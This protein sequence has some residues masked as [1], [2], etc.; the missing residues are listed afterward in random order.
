MAA[1]LLAAFSPSGARAWRSNIRAAG[2]LPAPPSLSDSVAPFRHHLLLLYESLAMLGGRVFSIEREGEEHLHAAL[3]EGKGLL[4]I[5][6]H[7]GN[8]HVGARD[9]HEQTGRPIHSVAG[10]QFLGSWTEELRGAY[11]RLGLEIHARD[12][13]ALR[14]T[15]ILRGGGIV[16]LHLDGDQHAGLGP[17]TRGAVLLSRRTGCPLLPAVCER[18]S[19]GRFVV[20]FDRPLEGGAGAPDPGD[21]SRLLFRMVRGRTGQWA[22]F[23][24]LMEGR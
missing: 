13:S 12:G 21:L 2:L 6:A 5:T 11:R 23:R 24:P 22:L 16:A 4:V 3:R 10:V 14:L 18:F 9:L 17:A 8:W 20:R 19:P 7:L 15:R 1:P